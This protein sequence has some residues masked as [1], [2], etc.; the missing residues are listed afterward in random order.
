[1]NN[2]MI[3]S[4]IEEG[5]IVTPCYIG[6]EDILTSHI[7]IMKDIAGDSVD[8][9]YAMK[10]NP[11]FTKHISELVEHIE[12][13]SPGE[14]SVCKEL[15]IPGKQIIFSGVNKTRAD[16][17]CALDYGVD[18]ITLESIKHFNLVNELCRVKSISTKILIRLSSGAQFGMSEE[19][20]REIIKNRAEYPYLEIE[21]IHYFTG[22]QKKK[23]DKDIEEIELIARLIESLNSDYQYVCQRFEYGLG[24][25]V[26]YFEGDDFEGIYADLSRLVDYIKGANFNYRITFELGRFITSS[27]MCYLTSIDDLKR[28]EGNNVCLV[29]G[30]IHQ[31]NYYGQNMAMRVPQIDVIKMGKMPEAE[32][33]FVANGDSMWKICGSLCTFADVLV[34]KAELG[35]LSLGDVL[36]FK[37]AGAYSITEAPA[38]FLSRMM[39][40]IY[41][42]SKNDGFKAVRESKESYKINL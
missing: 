18:V 33:G 22:T 11:F 32:A 2:E 41:I 17:E 16:V 5:K 10:A 6:D 28:V 4:L 19:E 37:N 34:R 7:Q 9:C 30:G 39:P 35:E 24:L 31:L 20:L 27:S 13:C 1:M 42:F 12:V 40:N 29:D 23:I 14:L 15:G 8:Y 38:L 21:G 3:K 26:P 25:S 36:L